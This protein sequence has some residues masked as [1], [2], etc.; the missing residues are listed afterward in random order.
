MHELIR[1]AVRHEALTLVF[2]MLADQRRGADAVWVMLCCVVARAA[3]CVAIMP[4]CTVCLSPHPAVRALCRPP[5][6][7]NLTYM[8][9]KC[10]G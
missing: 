5:A 2:V 8:S 3:L 4:S 6:A 9:T 10:N 1:L 7:T